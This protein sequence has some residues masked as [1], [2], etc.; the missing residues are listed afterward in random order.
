[1]GTQASR[2]SFEPACPGADY[3]YV[4]FD[5]GARVRRARRASS[6]AVLDLAPGWSDPRGGDPARRDRRRGRTRGHRRHASVTDTVILDSNGYGMTFADGHAL[7][8]RL[9]RTTRSRARA[10]RRPDARELRR[11]LRR[12]QHASHG[13]NTSWDPRPRGRSGSTGDVVDTSA[14]VARD[15]RPVRGSGRHRASA[16]VPARSGSR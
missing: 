9:H 3:W 10:S 15:R 13:N 16:V 4:G 14:D 5:F 2:S 12:R 1:M 8:G 7:R 11:P 6:N